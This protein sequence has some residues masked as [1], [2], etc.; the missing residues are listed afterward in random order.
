MANELL[1]SLKILLSQIQQGEKNATDVVKNLNTWARDIGELIKDKVEEEVER[2][3]KK[4]G[5]VKKDE[6]RALEIRVQRLESQLKRSSRSTV[7]VSEKISTTK[8]AK[9]TSSS[10][11]KKRNTVKKRSTTLEKKSARGSKRKAVKA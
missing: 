10:I 1:S 6:Y 2:S 11:S 9:N 5:F 3:V 4:M 7:K 8:K